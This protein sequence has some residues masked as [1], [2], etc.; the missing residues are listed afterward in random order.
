MMR[1]RHPVPSMGNHPAMAFMP[2]MILAD[3]KSRS[4]RQALDELAEA[5]ANAAGVAKSEV[6]DALTARERLGTTGVGQGVAL[7]HA[8]LPGIDRLYSVFGRAAE[9]IPFDA[10]DDKP[11]DL[12]FLLLAP[13]EA[14]A[15][16]LKALARVA[17]LLRDADMCARLRGADSAEAIQ[18]LLSPRAAA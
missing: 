8:R 1:I 18:A 16:H 9:A 17:R 10:V 11:V 14:S 5:A 3:M 13:E 12:F 7:P 6:L 4:K 15:E 2:D